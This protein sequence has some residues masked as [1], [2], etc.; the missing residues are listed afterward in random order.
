VVDGGEENWRPENYSKE[1][2]GP[3]RL[4]EALV[5][6]RNLVSIRILQ[7]IGLDA[8]MEHA[9]KFGFDPKSMP[10]NLTLALGTLSASPLDMATGFA[11]FANGGYKVSP[12][13][14]DHIE[15][16][17]GK[18]VYQATPRIA[19][20]ECELQAQAPAPTPAAAEPGVNADGALPPEGAAALVTGPAPP[21]IH[22]VDAP[23]PLRSLAQLQG[24]RGYLPEQ[25]L[26]PRVISPQNAW[27]MTNIM[28]DVV[29]RGTATRARA[30]GRDDL[31]G[32]TGTSND[33]R[34]TW[35]NG[36][37]GQLVA[38]VWVG[39]DEERSLGEGEDGA[40][41]AIPI[42]MHFMR[43]ALRNQPS[44]TLERPGG[45]I[46]LKVSPTTGLLADP[47][48]PNAFYETFLMNHLPQPQDP[49]DARNGSNAG[50]GGGTAAGAE[51]L[52]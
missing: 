6:S 13:L 48:D 46:D 20:S 45:L 52:F 38:T 30:L 35:F 32:K 27:L 41:T 40:R 24:G 49:N 33:Q 26:A 2:G 29:L 17:T 11:V 42:W 47:L 10:R 21:R 15:D 43:E 19:C 1:F 8:A 23:E 12:Y 34:D 36:F 18:S 22:E 25:R 51:P 14:I 3:T 44:R 7:N 4:R 31:A 39:Y 28:K 5:R 16:A 50:A 9:A 37:N